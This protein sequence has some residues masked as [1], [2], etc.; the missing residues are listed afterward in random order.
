MDEL[1][2]GLKNQSEFDRFMDLCYEVSRKVRLAS[3]RGATVEEI[4]R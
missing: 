1:N 2:I 3:L 4:E